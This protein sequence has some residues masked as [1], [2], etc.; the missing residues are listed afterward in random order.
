MSHL[1]S[2]GLQVYLDTHLFLHLLLILKFNKYVNELIIDIT[3]VT[4]FIIET[5]L[6]S[7]LRFNCYSSPKKK[8]SNC[9]LWLTKWKVD[10]IF[11]SGT[12]NCM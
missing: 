2:L 3:L 8:I 7:C 5:K 4:I 9:I 10:R 6:H 1:E 12:I 11:I